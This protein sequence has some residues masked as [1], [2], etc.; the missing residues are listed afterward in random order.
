M[1]ILGDLDTKAFVHTRALAQEF[2]V[3]IRTV[4]R[5]IDLLG[6]AGFPLVMAEKGK[7][8][9]A[10]GFSLGKM[11]LTQKEAS[12]LAF[13]K[14]I[15]TSLGSEFDTV[16]SGLIQKVLKVNDDLPYFIKMPQVHFVKEDLIFWKDLEKAIEQDCKTSVD[17]ERDAAVKTYTLCPLKLINYDGFWYLLAIKEG[18][19]TAQKFR[20]DKIKGVKVLNS[21]FEVPPNIQTLLNESTSVWFASSRDKKVVLKIDNQVAHFFKK[22]NYFPLQKIVKEQKD[23]ITVE[24]QTGDYMEILPTIRHWLPHITIISPIEFKKELIASLKNYIK[25]T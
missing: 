12:L 8:A 16:F 5:D 4:Q 23:G 6:M 13:F 14:E 21:H 9:F 2:N 1:R 18:E 20:L 25:A 24:T 22:K 19:K 17:Y 7:Y 3:S 15:S 11:K 10:E